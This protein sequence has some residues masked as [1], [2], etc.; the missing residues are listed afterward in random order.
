MKKLAV[1][2]IA[3]MLFLAA[4]SSDSSMVQPSATTAVATKAPTAQPSTADPDDIMFAQMMIPHHEQAVEMTALVA[5][6]SS[7]PE[8]KEL[9]LQISGAQQPEIDLMKSWLESWGASTSSDHA[10]H[11]AGLLSE[12]QMNELAATTGVE[13]DKLFL[14]GMIAHHEGAVAMASDELTNG[15]DPNA[16]N[17]AME[18]VN[19]QSVEIEYM[20]KLL[21]QLS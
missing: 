4:C 12:D 8:V 18:I 2:T 11:M 17:L 14:S 15:A 13:F 21:A 6:R 3:P 19:S 20:K 16:V 1:L 7:M 10:G 9:A 5:E